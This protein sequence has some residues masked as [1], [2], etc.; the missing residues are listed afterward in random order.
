MG[1]KNTPNFSQSDIVAV[2]GVL[3]LGV[4]KVTARYRNLRSNP[5]VTVMLADGWKRQAI[6]EGTATFMDI[7][8]KTVEKTLSAQQ[9]NMVGSQT[10]SQSSSL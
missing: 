10:H 8:G 3:Y 5:A 4:D 6:I 7:E 1:P 9:K 2:D